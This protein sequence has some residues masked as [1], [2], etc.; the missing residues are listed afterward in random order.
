MRRLGAPGWGA[1]AGKGAPPTAGNAPWRRPASLFVL[2]YVTAGLI[3]AALLTLPAA[4]AR[5]AQLSFVDAL[6][7]STSALTVCGLAVIDLGGDLSLFGRVV[8]A[9]LI[10]IGGI[11]IMSLASLLGLAVIHRF[12]LRLRMTLSQEN[13]ALGTGDVR[14]VVLRILGVSLL[15]EAVVALVLFPRF[16]LAHGEGP[17]AAAGLG[18]F[19]AVSAFNN[20]GLALYGDSLTRFAADPVI[21]TVIAAASIVGG[22]G[23]PVLLEIR[24]HL[25][26][27]AQWSLHTKL[28]L[29]TTAL[30]FAGGAAAVTLLEWNNP[31]TL[32]GMPWWQRLLDGGFHGVMPRSGGFNV[33]DTGAMH[34]ATLM[35]TMM[36]MFVGGG[37]AGT[38]GGIKVVTLAVVFLV[39][40]AEIRGRSEVHV[41]GR[42]LPPDVIRQALSLL[43]LSMTVVVLSTVVLLGT[44][45]FGL[46][47]VM[48]EVI[49]AFGVVGLST[50]VT[51]DLP[52]AAHVLL[53]V[54]MVAGRIGPV[55][56]ATALALRERTR[57]FD[58]PVGRP[59]IG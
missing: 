44:T 50:G 24:R 11:G 21:L 35:V 59:F 10:Q 31:A 55:T 2:V 49:S 26:R 33:V 39:V 1:L 48:F 23:F 13:R 45:R 3:G 19:H 37:T 58:R 57:R 6:F 38:A 43:F 7:T 29:V 5:D 4:H 14:G 28:T 25:H 56:F 15:C 22:L 42:K 30:L 47:P 51:P 8:V 20:A 40:W 46:V 12:G 34:D 54:L 9:V 41:F 53:A 16:W 17:L 18:A 27:H 52:P 32:G 36:L